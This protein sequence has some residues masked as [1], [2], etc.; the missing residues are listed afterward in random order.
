MAVY[1]FQVNEVTRDG[2]ISWDAI[3]DGSG[4]RV[5]LG[6]I[7]VAGSYP[8]IDAHF[9]TDHGLEVTL[10]Y[11]SRLGDKLEGQTWTFPRGENT[12]VVRDIPRT[13]F[14]LS[15]LTP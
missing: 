13:V 5:A 1:A 14:R 3:E 10:S 8:E 7:L 6:N 2:F 11:E 15:G 9:K 12:V 4:H